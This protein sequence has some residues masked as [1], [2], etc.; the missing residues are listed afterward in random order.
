MGSDQASDVPEPSVSVETS[1]IA[2]MAYLTHEYLEMIH[3][4]ERYHATQGEAPTDEMM[5]RRF[6][7]EQS[8]LEDFK[9]HPL[10]QKSFKYR[11]I[12]Y[13]SMKDILN[14]RQ[15]MAIATMTNYIDRRSDE[16]KL[17]DLGISSREWATW[18][19]DDEFQ[20]YLYERSERMFVGAQHEAHLGLIKGVR[21][22]NVASVKLYNEM[23]GRHNPEADNN[24]NVRLLLHGII[25][26][27]QK[28][29]KD[30]VMLHSIAGEMMNFAARQ[31]I[32]NTSPGASGRFA[33]P[34]VAV[35][36]EIALKGEL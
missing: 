9:F 1:T 5:H 16:K 6:K 28:H 11:G 36:K 8:T 18:L 20:K 31:S 24:L 35:Q 33:P 23:T 15:L 17:R 27:L 19:L 22:G 26:I 12:T 13:P 2:E 32:D 3:F 21:N 10:V 14:D 25:E 7:V 30:P 29:V 4:I 34:V